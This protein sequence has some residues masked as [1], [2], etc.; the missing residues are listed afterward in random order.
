[1][2]GE[3]FKVPVK[4]YI[5]GPTYRALDKYARDHKLLGVGEVLELLATRATQPKPSKQLRPREPKQRKPYVRMTPERLNQL[6]VMHEV[7]K[8]PREISA[9]LGCSTAN[10]VIH[11]KRLHLVE[12]T[13]R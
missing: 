7:G 1:M 5:S 8:T 3:Q 9:A 12:G 11:L 10:V 4:A 2:N 6:V 13:K